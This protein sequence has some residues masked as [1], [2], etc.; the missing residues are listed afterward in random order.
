M[1]NRIDWKNIKSST[2]VR[3]ALTL[4]VIINQIV[5][6]I[7]RTSFATADWYQVLTLVCTIITIP[8]MSWYNNDYTHYAILSSK[9]L[10][11]LNTGDK[12]DSEVQEFLER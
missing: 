10:N 6:G 4:I 12:T 1:K 5:A 9:I 8:I 3:S 2:I 7:G 11:A